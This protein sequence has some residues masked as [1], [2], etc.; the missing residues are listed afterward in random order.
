M[1]SLRAV[2]KVMRRRGGDDRG[3]L[4]VLILGLTVIAMTLI[5]G[6]LAVTSV[7]ISRMRLLDA[8]DSAALT[9]TDDSAEQ[10]YSEGVGTD[11][12]LNDTLVRQ[13]AADHLASRSRPHGLESWAVA[14]G[15]GTPDGQTAVV[16]LSGQADLPLI[17]GLLESMGGSVTVTVE[18]RARAGVA[19][20]V[21]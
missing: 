15:T 6:G 8:A 18:S 1:T 3:Q 17:G 21:P 10:I 5:I 11:L 13:S 4:T 19:A 12:P 16:R 9:A 14:P 2:A 20:D 7:Q